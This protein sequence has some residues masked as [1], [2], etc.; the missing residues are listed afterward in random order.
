MVM[1]S[2]RANAKWIMLLVAL[3]FVGWM[4]FDV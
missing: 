3:A 2:M 1:R 4:V